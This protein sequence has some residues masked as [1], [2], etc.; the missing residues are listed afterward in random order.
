MIEIALFTMFGVG[1]CY[2]IDFRYQLLIR[3]L[4][5]VPTKPGNGQRVGKKIRRWKSVLTN[6]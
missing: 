5:K 4:S 3:M 6:Y 2:F 1:F